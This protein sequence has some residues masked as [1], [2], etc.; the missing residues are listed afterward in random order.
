MKTCEWV[1][2][3]ANQWMKT[4]SMTRKNKAFRSYYYQLR[5]RN[6]LFVL[7]CLLCS[8]AFAIGKVEV[9]ADNDNKKDC[10]FLRWRQSVV[11]S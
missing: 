1:C 9:F 8:F 6:W 7:V 10:R 4:K 5:L 2:C 3:C 11:V